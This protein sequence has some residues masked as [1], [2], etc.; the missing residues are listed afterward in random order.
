MSATVAVLA[1]SVP[2]N[3][4]IPRGRMGVGDSV[5]RGAASELQARGFQGRH[6]RESYVL[7]APRVDAPPEEPRQAAEEG[8]RP[9]RQQRLPGA[10]RLRPCH[11]DQ[12]LAPPRVPRDAEGSATVARRQQRAAEVVCPASQQHVDH[13]L[14]RPQREPPGMVRLRPLPPDCIGSAALRRVHRPQE[15]LNARSLDSFTVACPSGRR[16]TPGK[17][18]GG[19]LPRGFESLGHRGS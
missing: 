1:A 13:R 16:D 15:R 14:V 2:A 9:P 3:A 7:I 12:P 11:P 17:R 5:M 8:D 19:Q 6:R 4:A 18:V 10:E